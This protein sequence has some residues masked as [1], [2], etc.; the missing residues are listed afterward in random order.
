MART[1]ADRRPIIA[2]TRLGMGAR[3]D[4][5]ARVGDAGG[6]LR[7]QIRLGGAANPQVALP[8]TDDQIARLY[9]YR[10]QVAQAR[11]ADADSG[12]DPVRE[13]RRILIDATAA[14]FLARM[15][16]ACLTEAGFAERWALFWTNW[17]SV[18]ATKFQA[19]L[20]IPQYEAEAI[21]PR[22]FGRFSDL[23]VA[24]EAHP[25]M[26]LYL[27]QAQS[28]GPNSSVGQRR[29]AG[30]NENLAREI[31]ELH[32]VGADAGY[33]QADVTEF[34]RALTGWSISAPPDAPPAL[35]RQAQAG[36][37]GFVFRALVHEPGSRTVMGHSYRQDGHDQALA[38]L[39]DL[40]AHP[41]TARRAAHRIAAH[42]IADEPPTTAVAALEAAWIDSGG[43][44][45]VVATTLIGLPEVW[46]APQ[47]KLKSPYELIVSGYRA[48]GLAPTRIEHVQPILRQLGQPP[49][50][51]ASPEGWPDEAAAWGSPDAVV[52]RMGWAQAFA[53]AVPVPLAPTD[54]AEAVLGG[55]LSERTR[56]AVSRAESRSEAVALLLMSPEFQRR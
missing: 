27:D 23:L 37:N 21:R 47:A 41:A 11:R 16:L 25:A 19:A 36:S 20:V 42:F 5:L 53:E 51:P 14:A 30:L 26:L 45:A 44:L 32:T 4:D 50:S 8:P 18:S 52:T 35:R 31:L 54:L 34:A 46:T 38:I 24:A 10:D 15:R 55:L 2:L 17:F 13:A 28:V 40:A 6:W 12:R 43:D 48:I 1:T 3:P 39:N 33:T 56:A 22:V 9:A 49:Y 29:E 7:G